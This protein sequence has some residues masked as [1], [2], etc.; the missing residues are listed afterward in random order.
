MGLF[1]TIKEKIGN[2][3]L[4]EPIVDIGTLVTKDN[5]PE[6]SLSIRQIKGKKPQLVLA[7][8]SVGSM[9][10]QTI[11]CSSEWANQ[12]ERVAA[13]MRKSLENPG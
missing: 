13:E 1:N 6:L 2:Q 11:T 4:G 8:K 7:W 5:G 3:L 12:F 9:D 10:Y